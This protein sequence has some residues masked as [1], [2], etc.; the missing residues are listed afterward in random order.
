M[1]ETHIYIG[2]E[3]KKKKQTNKKEERNKFYKDKQIYIWKNKLKQG[4]NNA[5]RQA[6]H[7][8][9]KNQYTTNI[10]MRNK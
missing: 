5:Q 6:G 10:Y 2:R 3:L 4:F 8:K 7:S 9:V 1:I